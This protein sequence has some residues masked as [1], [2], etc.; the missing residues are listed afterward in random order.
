MNET[1][2]LPVR[3]SPS[4]NWRGIGSFLVLCF[5]LT[6]SIEI[7]AL[8]RG[9]RFTVLTPATTLLLALVM[10]IPAA[11]AFVV[12][13]WIT[14][15]G[16]ASAG[17]R[18]GAVKPYLFIWVGVP[19]LFFVIYAVTCTLG[20]GVFSSASDSIFKALPPLPPGKHMPS[21]RTPILLVGIISVT[22]G[23][24]LTS[25]A[26]FGEEFG[27]TGYLLPALLPLGRWRA[28]AI[29]GVIW[30]LWHAPI[31]AG[32]FNYPG[33]PVAGILFMCLFTSALGLIQCALL[34]RYRSVLLT[35][36]LHAAINTQAR[37]VWNLLVTGVT[38]LLGGLLGLVGVAS[39]AI[40]GSLLLV[41]TPVRLNRP[42]PTASMR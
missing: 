26:T 16:F 27:W 25:L 13:R 21:A 36:F 35:S 38:P 41:R 19:C 40:V 3:T 37:G 17:L 22:I 8:A 9:V 42:G 6:W 14:R 15:E 28:V 24:L 4:I 30:G 20:L 5:G 11:S 32:G 12:R 33:H 18:F 39:I 23:P 10:F 1:L 7:I 34:V 31:V 2:E 29:Y